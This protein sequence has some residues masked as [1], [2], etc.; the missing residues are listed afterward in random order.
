MSSSQYFRRRLLKQILAV[1]SALPAVSI[2]RELLA[3]GN[4]IDEQSMSSSNRRALHLVTLRLSFEDAER[5]LKLAHDSGFNT[6][7]P[8]IVWK[9]STN[10]KSTPWVKSNKNTWSR[11]MLQ[12]LSDLARSLGIDVIPQIPLLT[13]ADKLFQGKR[14][15]L[16]YNKSTYN[17]SN[18]EVYEAVLPVIDEVIELMQPDS[19]HIGHDEVWGWKDKDYKKGRL[20]SHEKILPADLYLEHV[21]EIHAYLER[22]KVRTWMW[23]DMLISKEEFPGMTSHGSL[24][25][26][27]DQ[28]GYGKAI[29]KLVPRDIVICDWHYRN[30]KTKYPTLKTFLDADFETLGAT[31]HTR[32][33]TENF[34]RYAAEHGAS[35]MIATTWYYVQRK[36]WLT[37]ERII[38][39][40]GSIY[41]RYFP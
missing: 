24:H 20:E 6:F 15:E 12:E 14:P 28:F 11:S 5:L 22:K 31:F 18:P 25:P 4:Q 35:G 10:L 33:I 21:R 13:K 1:I 17:P 8:A 7:I 32:M 27:I 26:R 40:S 30:H 38:R 23:G 3:A 36:D 39:E 16:L 41:S 37:V 29:R 2:T 19:F 34:S 9:G